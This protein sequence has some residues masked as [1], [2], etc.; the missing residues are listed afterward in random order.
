MKPSYF[1]INSAAATVCKAAEAEN[2]G[3]T[4]LGLAVERLERIAVQR[5]HR[6]G[7]DGDSLAPLGISPILD[8]EGAPW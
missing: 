5:L 1:G 3:S 4:P 6:Q 7:S 2:G 8:L